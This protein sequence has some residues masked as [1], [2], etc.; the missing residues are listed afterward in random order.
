MRTVAVEA[1]WQGRSGGAV[2]KATTHK[3]TQTHTRRKKN[4]RMVGCILPRQRQG[5]TT[6]EQPPDQTRG[7]GRRH[8]R[9]R[10]VLPPHSRR[11]PGSSDRAAG[12]KEK[13]K[14]RKWG[15]DTYNTAPR[16]AARHNGPGRSVTR[17][18]RGTGG[19]SAEGGPPTPPPR[20][21]LPY[22][23]HP[24]ACLSVAQLLQFRVKLHDVFVN[25]L[26]VWVRRQRLLSPRDGEGRQHGGNGA[27]RA[28]EPT[29]PTPPARGH[30]KPCQL[31]WTRPRVF[32]PQHLPEPLQ[33]ASPA[34]PLRSAPRFPPSLPVQPLRHTDVPPVASVAP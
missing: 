13:K 11:V 24:G 33:Q 18:G 19:V 28:L 14:R 26:D 32:Q 6:K 2:V 21:R 12:V 27:A 10:A 15:A 30:S 23:S 20:P 34:P 3:H 22:P 1:G 31:P 4:R 29:K 8:R 7:G 25:D 5:G 17:A 16:T 9:A